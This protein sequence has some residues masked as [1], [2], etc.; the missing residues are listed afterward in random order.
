MK[1]TKNKPVPTEVAGENVQS[2]STAESENTTGGKKKFK[3]SIKKGKP[4]V[5]G[6]LAVHRVLVGIGDNLFKLFYP[7]LI[8]NATGR[9]EFSIFLAVLFILMKYATSVVCNYLFKKLFYRN[10]LIFVAINVVITLIVQVLFTINIAF[11]T[12]MVVLTGIL[13]G[14]FTSCYGTPINTLFSSNKSKDTNKTVQMFESTAVLGKMIAPAI[15]GILLGSGQ[16]IVSLILSVVI[17]GASVVMLFIRY[18]DIAHIFREIELEQPDTIYKI[19]KKQNAMYFAWYFLLGVQNVAS[20]YFWPVW[21][22]IK[23][24]SVTSIG[25]INSI[26]LVAQFATMFL[27]SYLG[28]KN[29]WYLPASVCMVLRTA[30]LIA[31]P[32]CLSSVTLIVYSA[33]AGLLSP[34]YNN[35]FKAEFVKFSKE[36]N[37]LLTNMNYMDTF[38]YYGH[39]TGPLMFFCG[40]PMVACIII[41]SVP[42]LF[43]WSAFYVLK[44]QKKHKINV[45]PKPTND[46][47]KAT[48]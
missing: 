20:S 31:M 15:G 21:L 11:T 44:Y 39:L 27:A 12:E 46:Y 34:M 35:T 1:H 24:V 9:T 25:Y 26:T 37:I 28:R 43:Q 32:F 38:Y 19:V 40:V 16:L 4:S 48:Y 36:N 47:T 5:N 17:Y 8:Y 2:V 45:T 18:K 42:F 22:A 10:A 3:F 14:L 23:Q 33:V 7:V 13:T 30:L 41:G 6:C 29:K